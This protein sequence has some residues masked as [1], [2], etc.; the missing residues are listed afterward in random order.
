MPT[1]LIRAVI[2]A[3]LV[4]VASGFTS[5]AAA[6]EPG[7][8]VRLALGME[9]GGVQEDPGP[10]R[11]EAIA[12]SVLIPGWGQR[13]TGHNG[14]AQVFLGAEIGIWTAFTVFQVQGR[15]RKDSYIELA[16]VLAGVPDPDGA[17]DDYYRTIGFFRSTEDYMRDV[18][19]DARARFGDDLDARRAYEEQNAIPPGRRWEWKSD[20]DRLRYRSKRSDSNG[21]FQNARYMIAAAVLNRLASAMDAARSVSSSDKVAIHVR[22]DPDEGGPLQLCLA[23][24]VP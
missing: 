7:P 2:L 9:N 24:P 23:F 16:E 3:S 14:R 6:E 1:H 15:L 17:D 8:S 20:A 13:A 22:P 10:S 5:R 12:K 11:I 19:R 21:A 18:R 4:V